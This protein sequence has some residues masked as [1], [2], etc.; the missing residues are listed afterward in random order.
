MPILKIQVRGFGLRRIATLVA[1]A[2]LAAGSASAEDKSRLGN[3][4]IASL[5]HGMDMSGAS[6]QVVDSRFEE[7]GTAVVLF[8]IVGGLVNSGINGSEDSKKAEPY[9][10]VVAKLEPGRILSEKLNATLAARTFPLAAAEKGASH[11]LRVEIKEWGL[12]RTALRD[13][14]LTTF[15]RL[16]VVMK[17]GNKVV[18]DTYMKDSG[19]RAAVLPEMTSDMLVEDIESLA[20]KMGERIAYEIIYR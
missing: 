5:S 19:G 4:P 1:C 12:T 10:G 18:W 20:A 7:T 11:V 14:R 8:G 15:I 17:Q 2:V 16:H 9:A 13:D 3:F 6:F